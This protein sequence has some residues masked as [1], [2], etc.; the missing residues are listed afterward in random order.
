MNVLPTQS[1][2][3]SPR[4]L[5]GLLLAAVCFTAAVARGQA[6]TATPSPPPEASV[7]HLRYYNLLPI[8]SG[9]ITI[10]SGTTAWVTGAKPGFYMNYTPIP[11]GESMRFSVQSK[12]Q[13]IEAFTLKRGSADTYYTIVTL[14][15]GKRAKAILN[16]DNQ[17]VPQ[18]PD[19]PPPPDKWV[20]VY[21]GAFGFPYTASAGK[22]GTWDVDAESV[23][24]RIPVT[25][26]P[27]PTVGISYVTKYGEKVQAFFPLGFDTNKSNSVFVSQRGPLRPRLRCYPDNVTNTDLLHPSTSGNGDSAGSP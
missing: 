1:T 17:V 24:A 14:Q 12:G 10:A 25:T 16:L 23:V 2:K 20:H 9:E 4:W 19:E 18:K 22:L 15:Q 21:L 27:P 5:S 11:S 8:E 7:V 26:T 13:E 6:P 3:F